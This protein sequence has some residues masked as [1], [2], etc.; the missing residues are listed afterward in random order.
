[1]DWYRDLRLRWKLLGA[2]GLILS[3]TTLLSVAA[4]RG[5]TANDE[6]ARDVRQS[7][8]AIRLA[9]GVLISL[10][11]METGLRGFLL[12]GDDSFLAPYFAGRAEYRTN[13]ETLRREVADRPDQ[14][15]S[16]QAI[17]AR[18]VD[19]ERSYAEPAIALRRQ[20]TDGN[21]S[22]NDVMGLVLGGAGKT[23]FDTL[24]GDFV[25]ANAVEE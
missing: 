3:M 10:V 14:V 2:V 18:A 11:N 19:W 23:R 21:V 20:V 15:A 22:L 24:R 7:Q 8:E 4:F 9:D 17:E 1:M 16:W 13:L 6:R 25:R 12:T 5:M